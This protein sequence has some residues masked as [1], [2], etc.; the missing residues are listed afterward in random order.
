MLFAP[1]GTL[2]EAC[3][4]ALL[5]RE[6]LYG[7]MLTQNMQSVANLSESTL[8]PVLRRLEKQGLL[9]VYDQQFQGRNRRYLRHHGPRAARNLRRTAQNGTNIKNGLS[10]LILQEEEKTK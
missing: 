3:V 5:N 1:S 6:D 9:R 8:Y 10:H 4:L 2:L 7:Y